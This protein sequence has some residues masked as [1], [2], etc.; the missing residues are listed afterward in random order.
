MARLFVTERELNFIADITREIV[1][2][3]VGQCIYYYSVSE[4]KTKTHDVYTEA[5][6]KIF[7]N[8]IKIDAFV[9]NI[10]QTDTKIDQFGVDQRYKLDVFLQYRDLNEKGIN[11]SLGDFFSFGDVFYEIT[12]KSQWREIDWTQGSC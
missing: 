11:I 9:D 1:K 12:G 5:M 4:L 7:D 3:V 8:P 10:Y 6:Q 2:D